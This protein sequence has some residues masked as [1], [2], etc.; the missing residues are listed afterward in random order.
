MIQIEDVH[1]A[2][3]HMYSEMLRR[4]IAEEEEGLT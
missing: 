3:T 2:F 4:M 1:L